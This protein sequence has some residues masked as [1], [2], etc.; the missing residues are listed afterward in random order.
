MIILYQFPPV[1]GLPNAS[2]FCMKIET[3]L[4]MAGIGYQTVIVLDPRKAPKHKL[5]YIEDGKHIVADSALILDHLTNTRGVTLDHWLSPRQH[6][7]G[8]AFRRMMEE[9]TYWP[10]LY[11]RW[12]EE[13]GFAITAES[14]MGGVPWPKRKIIS[15]AVRKHYKRLLWAQGTGRHKS[16]E[17]A[18]Q[19]RRDLE[20]FA[21]WLGDKPF[22]LGDKLT[23]YD[24]T[25]YP[26]LANTLDVPV[27]GPLQ[28]CA[29][30]LPNLRL[31]VDR[32]RE[33]FF[34]TGTQRS[35]AA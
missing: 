17:I 4:R 15:A 30:A 24:A 32:M 20:A 11:Y 35:K 25:F 8:H 33:T 19:G 13:E 27:S 5:P 31:Y 34:P 29:R 16:E 1:W 28:D 6:A 22:A 3:F 12:V 10:L 26:F 9:A 21:A 23:S 14:F 7:E 18:D 2:P